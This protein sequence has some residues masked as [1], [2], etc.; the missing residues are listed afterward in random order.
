MTVRSHSITRTPAIT[1]AIC[2]ILD[3][4]PSIVKR[5]EIDGSTQ[6]IEVFTYALCDEDHIQEP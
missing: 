4:D 1:D 3:I 5:I 2:S 6:E